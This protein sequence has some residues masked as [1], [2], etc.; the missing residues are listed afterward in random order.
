MNELEAFY[1]IADLYARV[2]KHEK[3]KAFVQDFI[4]ILPKNTAGFDVLCYCYYKAKDYKNAI[5]YGEMALG[6]STGDAA[7][8]IRFNLGKCYLNA[9]EPYKSRNCFDI[10]CK[11]HPERLD[12]K[13]DLAAALFACNQK[14][15]AK[16]L[17]IRLDE[18][19]WKFDKREESA[20][21]F[22][23]AAYLFKDGDFKLGMK[24]LSLG[25]QLRVFGADTHNYPIPKWDG[26]TNTGKHILIVG[27]GGIGDEIINARFV[28][29]I[30]DRGMKASFASCQ[31]MA[32]VFSKLPFETT[33]N[34]TK[35]TTD[36][37]N[38]IDYDYWT[39]AMSLPE[40]LDLSAPDLWY[41]PYLLPDDK[42]NIKWANR[43]TGEVK[44]GLRWSGNPLYEQDLHRSISLEQL[45]D[46]VPSKWTKYSIQKENTAILAQYPDITN[47]ENELETFDDTIACLSNLDI[48]ITSCTSVA[49]AAAALDKKV[50]LMVPIMEY[51]TWAEGREQSSWYGEN[52]T[53]I[54]QST[55]KNW[56]SAYATLRE[57]IQDLTL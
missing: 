42:H 23:L 14:D 41:G 56:D 7:D 9:N 33:Q 28:K 3:L 35:F 22:N 17:L 5:Y 29:H 16:E 51:Y 49:H 43:L 26:S 34:Y 40:V 44:V 11:L 37:K 50:F 45:Y 36:I 21:R 55:P 54:R 30:T 10:L 31:G 47:L 8:A 13:L 48:V 25:R 32:S 12:I 20:I 52:L 53:I 24:Y 38:I 6:A 1:R 18:E 57:K 19:S 39:P 46:I 27:E 15:E 2:D 4:D